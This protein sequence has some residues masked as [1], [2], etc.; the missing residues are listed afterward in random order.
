MKVLSEL[1]DAPYKNWFIHVWLW[2]D[3]S[4]HA[5]VVMR[6]A[7]RSLYREPGMY[8]PLTAAH[9]DGLLP[10]VLSEAIEAAEALGL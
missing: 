8:E 6:D 2:N 7:A 9:A 10:E 5:F 3:A 4:T 1:R